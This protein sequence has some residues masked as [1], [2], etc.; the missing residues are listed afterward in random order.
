MSHQNLEQHKPKITE[1]ILFRVETGRAVLFDV[2]EGEPF[3]LNESAT[4]VWKC[5]NG[6]WTMEQIVNKVSELY[7]A[8][9]GEI[10]KDIIQFVDLLVKKEFLVLT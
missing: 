3:L 8:E 9:S 10:R 4:D 2:V 6:E 7:E 1:N 5:C